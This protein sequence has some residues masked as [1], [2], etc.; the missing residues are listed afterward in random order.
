MALLRDQITYIW[1][2]RRDPRLW[3][4]FLW[5][6][7]LLCMI[8]LVVK[9]DRVGPVLAW[10]WIIICIFRGLL[11]SAWGLLHLRTT[12]LAQRVALRWA[13]WLSV[14]AS[15]WFYTFMQQQDRTSHPW[16]PSVLLLVTLAVF[17]AV[18][19]LFLV[20]SLYGAALGASAYQD[21]PDVKEAVPL[22]VT[23][24][25]F[26]VLGALVLTTLLRSLRSSLL[27]SAVFLGVNHYTVW[28]TMWLRGRGYEPQEL[29]P[30]LVNSV[31]GHLNLR[32]KYG[33]RLRQLDLRGITLGL[34]ASM[35]ALIVGN[36]L[37]LVTE[38]SALASLMRVRHQVFEAI[39]QQQV[40]VPPPRGPVILLRMDAAA[41]AAALTSRSESDLQ[42]EIIRKLHQLGVAHIVLPYPTLL[43]HQ[44][45]LGATTEA[46]VARTR[47]DL[48]Q[49]TEAMHEAGNVILVL[50]QET[51]TGPEARQLLRAAH[52]TASFGMEM[53]GSV[54]LPS[55]PLSWQDSPPL[56]LLLF[57]LEHGQKLIP[58]AY[59]DRLFVRSIAGVPL[60]QGLP[61]HILLDFRSKMPQSP[62]LFNES[63]ATV[64]YTALLT[65]K[66]VLEPQILGMTQSIPLT[67]YF[68]G[69]T[70]FLEPMIQA[71]LETPIGTMPRFEVLARITNTLLSGYALHRANA[72]WIFLLT[73]ILGA[74]V[75]HLCVRRDPLEASWRVIL[76]LLGIFAYTLVAFFKGVW[77]DAV[78]PIV[79]VSAAF[80]LIT[81]LTF[82]LERDARDRNRRLLQR[83]L[84]P[85]IVEQLLDAPEEAL[86]LGGD[87]R[88]VVVLFADVR[89]FTGFA[90]T[91]APEEVIEVVNHYMTA[92][93]D[94][95]DTYG[96]ILDKYTGDG[97]MAF[98][99]IDRAPEAEV[100][101]SV[102]AALAMRDAA[103]TLSARRKAEGRSVLNIGFGM[104]YGE[105]VVGLVGNRNRQINYTALGH[106]VVVSARLQTLAEGGEIVISEPMHEMVRDHFHV[107]CHSPVLVKGISAPMR[108]YF[109]LDP[110]EKP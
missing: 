97:L 108:P 37:L 35:F 104:H 103:L 16:P 33:G 88:R 99:L 11:A 63:I 86:G 70:V 6:L 73:L 8:G 15:L 1:N 9:P 110:V 77:V 36:Q 100:E 82:T 47:R 34:V 78:V 43:V 96:G 105:A 48:P 67:D 94:A 98:F 71:P 60:P 72:G 45:D 75:G 41:R 21:K 68:R 27:I 49:L 44:E 83:F 54:P 69:Q 101:R 31:L 66:P 58:E 42:A 81:R 52:D 22:S 28:L 107:V 51:H 79:A 90:E 3:V 12:L 32:W 24:W 85:K 59:G 7:N 20:F 5:W 56:P 19:T 18:F 30:R 57:A 65:D 89:N 93:T 61:G 14:L 84:A 74:L 10:I 106:T 80:L 95:L 38:E 102:L 92:L 2:L 29:V 17:P 62:V 40:S 64:A 87:K 76:L 53:Y 39:T 4:R 23:A 25:W 26:S 13:F 50:D 91:H 55:I 46:A 109:V